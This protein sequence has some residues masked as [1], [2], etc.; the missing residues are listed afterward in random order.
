[1]DI[2]EE[3]RGS[4]TLLQVQGRIDASTSS[5]LKTVLLTAID[6]GAKQLVV[7]FSQVDYISSAGLQ[8]LLVAGKKLKQQN[9]KIVFAALKKNIREVFDIAGFSSIFPA[10]HSQEEALKSFAAAASRQ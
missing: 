1:M 5:R 8:V 4:I 7:D 6:N 10:F 3:K 2:T 9:G